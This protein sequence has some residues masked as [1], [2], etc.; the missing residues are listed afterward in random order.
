MFNAQ[1]G[2]AI[3]MLDKCIMIS[4]KLSFLWISVF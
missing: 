2:L 3:N 4:I 1:K